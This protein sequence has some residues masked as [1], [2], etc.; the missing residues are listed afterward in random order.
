MKIGKD[1]GSL[2]N[3]IL[4]SC[5]DDSEVEV[6]M[7]ATFLYWTDRSPGTIVGILSGGIIAVQAD[8]YR[9]TDNLGMSEAQEYEYSPDPEGHISYFRKNKNGQWIGVVYSS[10]TR[11]W[12]MNGARLAVGFREKYYD[13]SF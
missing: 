1:T 10:K 4:G 3:G 7:G 13:Y 8:E 2:I 11:R 5:A 6:G 12:K 9:R